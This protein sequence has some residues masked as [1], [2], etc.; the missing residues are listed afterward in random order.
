MKP[1]LDNLS[2]RMGTMEPPTPQEDIMGNVTQEKVILYF[3]IMLFIVI[4]TSKWDAYKAKQKG[5]S[6]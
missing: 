6:K 3:A 5:T 1:G 2:H 4:A